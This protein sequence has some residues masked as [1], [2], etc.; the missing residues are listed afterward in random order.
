MP[1]SILRSSI[2]YNAVRKQLPGLAVSTTVDQLSELERE[3]LEGLR[4]DIA[5][6][7]SFGLLMPGEAQM[8][9][10]FDVER[11][12]DCNLGEHLPELVEVGFSLD[13]FGGCLRN[14]L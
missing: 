6:V 4:D 5:I 12:L 7:V 8:I 13:V 1:P 9:V 14:R 11:S 10:Q 2:D 3:G